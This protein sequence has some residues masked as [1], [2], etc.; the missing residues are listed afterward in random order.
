MISQL[1][2]LGVFSLCLYM[3]L[4]FSTQMVEQDVVFSRV[5]APTDVVVWTSPSLETISNSPKRYDD[6]TIEVIDYVYVWD[7]SPKDW[8]LGDEDHRSRYGASVGLEF[9]GPKPRALE[10]LLTE[11]LTVEAHNRVKVRVKGRVKDNCNIPGVMTCCFGRTM[12][13]IVETIVPVGNVER[14]RIAQEYLELRNV[15]KKSN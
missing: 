4:L 15:V 10:R 5:L 2:R 3:G 14:Y 7:F 8:R 1:I 6:K 11:N 12:T 9:N 13:I